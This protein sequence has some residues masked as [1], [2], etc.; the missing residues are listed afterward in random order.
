MAV[1][2]GVRHQP[3]LRELDQRLRARGKAVKVARVACMRKL[4]V[5]LNAR[6]RDAL[7]G[8]HAMA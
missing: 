3:R 6:M 2:V 8:N 4:L 1:L 5:I 7:R